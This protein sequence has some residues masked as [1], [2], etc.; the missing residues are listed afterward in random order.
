MAEGDGHS[1]TEAEVRGVVVQVVKTVK[2]RR[3]KELTLRFLS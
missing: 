1:S 2:L 3:Q